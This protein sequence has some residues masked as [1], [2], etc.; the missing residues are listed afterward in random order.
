MAETRLLN[1]NF[2]LTLWSIKVVEA[3]LL[4][5]LKLFK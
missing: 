1:G 3:L 4:N 5:A 2:L